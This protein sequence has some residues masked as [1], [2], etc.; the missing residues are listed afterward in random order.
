MA[1][2]KESYELKESLEDIDFLRSILEENTG[3]EVDFEVCDK[4]TVFAHCDKFKFSVEIELNLSQNEISIYLPPKKKGYFEYA[5]LYGLSSFIENHIDIPEY[6][7]K[8]W[9][10]LSFFEKAFKK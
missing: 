4:T 2:C 8:K 3:L 10:D 9:K 7:K 6:A 5:V 1:L